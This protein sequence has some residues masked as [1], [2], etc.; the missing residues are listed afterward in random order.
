MH[1]LKSLIHTYKFSYLHGA[2]TKGYKEDSVLLPALLGFAL[3]GMIL[4]IA[5]CLIARNKRAIV[6]SVRKRKRNVSSSFTYT[7]SKSY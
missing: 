6:S 4:I 3:I 2:A 1:I 5:I 7:A